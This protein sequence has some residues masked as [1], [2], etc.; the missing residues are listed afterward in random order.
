[1][2]GFD[3]IETHTWRS[4]CPPAGTEGREL[5]LQEELLLL[6]E[7]EFLLEGLRVCTDASKRASPLHRLW[8]EGLYRS[9]VVNAVLCIIPDSR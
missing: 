6:L 1:M 8:L 3:E 9:Y 4:V 5:L 2:G 7:E